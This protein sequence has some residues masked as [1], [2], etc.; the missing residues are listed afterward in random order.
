[1]PA[2]SMLMVLLMMYSVPVLIYVVLFLPELK[3][4]VSRA[5]TRSDVHLRR[6]ILRWHGERDNAC[7]VLLF[8]CL[9]PMVAAA[10]VALVYSLLAGISWPLCLTLM[11]ALA[12]LA[13][14]LTLT[15]LQMG[16]VRR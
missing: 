4:L 13:G 7:N 10:T 2:F 16:S 8:E 5:R 12:A 14:G 9:F 3:Q 11:G 15:F 1:M 6:T